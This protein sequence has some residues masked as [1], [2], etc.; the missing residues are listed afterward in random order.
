MAGNRLIRTCPARGAEMA[1]D[2]A[3]ATE[4]RAKSPGERQV[5]VEEAVRQLFKDLNGGSTESVGAGLL[6]SRAV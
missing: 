6:R 1:G 2:A 3:K 5:T 4:V